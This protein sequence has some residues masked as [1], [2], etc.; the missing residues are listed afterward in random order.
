MKIILL[1]RTPGSFFSTSPPAFECYKNNYTYIENVLRFSQF[2][3]QGGLK[4]E[5]GKTLTLTFTKSKTPNIIG[6][7]VFQIDHTKKY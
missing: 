7:P 3:N 1:I 4:K 5:S 6:L 2:C